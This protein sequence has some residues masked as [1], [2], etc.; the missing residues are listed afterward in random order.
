M[1]LALSR[2]APSPVA[3]AKGGRAL[4]SG[5]AEPAGAAARSVP[6]LAHAGVAV[7]ALTAPHC[8]AD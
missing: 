5:Q 3:A 6:G 1:T 2:F 8:S 7:D 4:G